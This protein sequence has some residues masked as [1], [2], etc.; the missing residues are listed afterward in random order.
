MMERDPTEWPP[1]KERENKMGFDAVCLNNIWR[2]M[3]TKLPK[4][5]FNR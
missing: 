5:A 1:S 2:V 4:Y 3:I